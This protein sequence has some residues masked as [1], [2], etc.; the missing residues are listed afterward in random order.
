MATASP[1]EHAVSYVDDLDGRTIELGRA[2]GKH[3]LNT[4]PEYFAGLGVSVEEFAARFAEPGHTIDESVAA[5]EM[6]AAEARYL[7][8]RAT[9][10]DLVEL[11]YSPE[12]IEAILEDQRAYACASSS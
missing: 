11:G 4:Q 8:L 3:L 7:Q 12:E 10:E 9:R 2:Y 5:G 1:L 6:S